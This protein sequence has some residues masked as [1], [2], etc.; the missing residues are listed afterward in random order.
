MEEEEDRSTRPNQAF[1]ARVIGGVTRGNQRVIDCNASK[2]AQ[3]AVGSHGAASLRPAL[4]QAKKK[5]HQAVRHAVLSAAAQQKLILCSALLSEVAHS[6]GFKLKIRNPYNVVEVGASQDQAVETVACKAQAATINAEADGITLPTFSVFSTDADNVTD[7]QLQPPL[8]HV[9]HAELQPLDVTI[10]AEGDDDDGDIEEEVN[11]SDDKAANAQV[12]RRVTRSRT[13]AVNASTP[14]PQVQL[15]NRLTASA[16]GAIG[17]GGRRAASMGTAGAH[18][19][20]TA[21]ISKRRALLMKRQTGPV[22]TTAVSA[23]VKVENEHAQVEL[24]DEGGQSMR[25][26]TTHVSPMIRMEELDEHVKNEIS[27]KS[28]AAQKRALALHPLLTASTMTPTERA[29]HSLL[30]SSSTAQSAGVEHNNSSTAMHLSINQQ[31][32]SPRGRHSH[33]AAVHVAE[34]SQLSSERIIRA[35]TKKKMLDRMNDAKNLNTSLKVGES[36]P[37]ELHQ[38]ELPDSSGNNTR[39]LP[40]DN[41]IIVSQ[42]A[43]SPKP[44]SK[45]TAAAV[46]AVPLA[47]GAKRSAVGS[48]M[49]VT[50]L[51]GAALR[52][53]KKVKDI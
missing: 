4:Q 38:L 33:T 18:N 27:G 16:L 26:D 10:L 25:T 43:A 47:S 28:T 45:S 20:V 39:V 8:H 24:A 23:G 49:G 37:L 30:S 7:G 34:T 46:P 13:S 52:D 22:T 29:S 6:F 21:A 14:R 42:V 2:A 48:P 12:R 50:G 41:N 11:F 1:L 31:V 3:K 35:S 32:G 19:A 44:S 36:S 5:G 15:M 40:V 51:F 9:T 53:I 17:L